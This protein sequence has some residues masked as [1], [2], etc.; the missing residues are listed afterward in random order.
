LDFFKKPVD[1]IIGPKPDSLML[2][3]KFVEC[4]E[5]AETYFRG[6]VMGCFIELMMYRTFLDISFFSMMLEINMIIDSNMNFKAF[7]SPMYHHMKNSTLTNIEPEQAYLSMLG[8]A[9]LKFERY[10]IK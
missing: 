2:N 5:F 10:Y 9:I 8:N 4:Y 1:T 7:S 3:H 6:N